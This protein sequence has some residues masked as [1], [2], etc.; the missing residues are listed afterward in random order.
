MKNLNDP[1]V[2]SILSIVTFEFKYDV[3][4]SYLFTLNRELSPESNINEISKSFRKSFI[5]LL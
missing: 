5:F 3:L 4:L 1:L 2:P